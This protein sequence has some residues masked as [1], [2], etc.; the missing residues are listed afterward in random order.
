MS[1]GS[2]NLIVPATG[3]RAT[4]EQARSKRDDDAKGHGKDGKDHHGAKIDWS[5]STL[6]AATIWQEANLS[7][8]VHNAT[9]FTPSDKVR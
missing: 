9:L 7:S 4:P 8:K 5:K 3:A 2:A 1:L 6:V